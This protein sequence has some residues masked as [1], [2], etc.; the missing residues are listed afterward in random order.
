V[1]VQGWVGAVAAQARGLTFGRGVGLL[2]KD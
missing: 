2:M 1:G